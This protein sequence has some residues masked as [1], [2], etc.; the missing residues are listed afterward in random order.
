MAS[1]CFSGL[2]DFFFF[3]FP[4]CFS[5]S[6]SEPR[7]PDPDPS[8]YGI[9]TPSLVQK[10]LSPSSCRRLFKPLSSCVVDDF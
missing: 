9:L 10:V 7:V 8:S 4:P 2:F 5:P 3:Q 1:N 6:L